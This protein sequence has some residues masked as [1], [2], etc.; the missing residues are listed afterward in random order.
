YPA[1]VNTSLDH[2][3]VRRQ[4]PTCTGSSGGGGCTSVQ[5]VKTNLAPNSSQP[6][7]SN[8]NSF[9][10]YFVDTAG[11][12]GRAEQRLGAPGPENL[13]SPIL[14]SNVTQNF[15]QDRFDTCAGPLAEPNRHRD[16]TP[17]V[18]NNST[19][20]TLEFRRTWT[21][22]TG[23][24]ITRL[25]FRI[26]D[27]TTVPSIAGV[28]DFRA[29]SSPDIPFTVDRPPCGTLF[30]SLTLRGTTVE[31]P[32]SQTSGGGY[33]TSL[34]VASVSTG[35]PLANNADVSVRFLLGVQQ[36][37]VGRF[38]AIPETVPA[39]NSRPFCFVGNSDSNIAWAPGDYDFDQIA[40]ITMY[41]PAT[42]QWKIYLTA[43]ALVS[44]FT[45]GGPGYMPVPADYDGDGRSDSGAY[46][47]SSGTWQVPLSSA[48]STQTLTFSWG[49]IGYQAVPGD[50]D[51]DGL[52]EIAVYN[53]ATGY[54]HMLTSTTAYQN[55][56]TISWGGPG[57]TP[58]AGQDFDGD[59]RS[60]LVVYN[61]RLGIWY[62]LKSTTNF[63][64]W[65]TM[66]WGGVGY[67]LVPGDYDGDGKSDFGLYQRG[68]GFWYILNS[69]TN[70]T[71][72]MSISFGGMGF[73]PMPGGYDRRGKFDIAV[74]QLALTK[75]FALT[76]S[77][78]YDV[79]SPIVKTVG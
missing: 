71:A 17:D 46:K 26:I 12:G 34:S 57:Y 2:A 3:Y 29:R 73:V 23:G 67:T 37:G 48:N 36:A 58:V 64:T 78:S 19:L 16:L 47:E 25:R 63:A 62:V 6:F 75:F 45:L 59:K 72:S 9:D 11:T 50:Y 55:S 65:F 18:P 32:P 53:P 31:Q 27:V 40:D 39:T 74:H 76:S 35:T 7:D 68:T 15:L 42:A 51:G 21:N 5:A 22:K 28:A 1:L 52:A 61:E 43:N 8:N 44:S 70:Y 69:S 13:S 54:W 49:G 41:N 24:N 10:F 4:V 38:C 77:S 20:G 56:L 14:T 30:P 33:N 79:G 66:A 60:D